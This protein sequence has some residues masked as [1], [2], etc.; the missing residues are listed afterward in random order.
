M[1][2][3]WVDSWRPERNQFLAGVPPSEVPGYIQ[4]MEATH[5]AQ[6]D[7][8][9]RMHAAGVGFLAGTDVS[10]WNFT[11]PGAS[12]HEELVQFVEAGLTPLEALQTAT[13]NPA[14]YLRMVDTVGIVAVGKRADVLVLDADP[15]RNISNTRTIFAVVVSGHL[16]DRSELS[17]LL[18]DARQRAAKGPGK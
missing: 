8:V 17:R 1:P 10:N 4:R 12:L 14:K 6:L 5:R 7:L 16:V 2:K 15:T 9:R 13:I 3:D 18:D 11:V